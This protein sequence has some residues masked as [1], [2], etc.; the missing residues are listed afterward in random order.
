MSPAVVAA[1]ARPRRNSVGRLAAVPAIAYR[2]GAAA[3]C[4]GTC[5]SCFK[6]KRHAER[7][8]PFVGGQRPKEELVMAGELA[9]REYSGGVTASVVVTCLMAA[10]CG[11]IFGFDFGVSGEDPS[12]CSLQLCIHTA[13]IASSS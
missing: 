5:I 2:P 3:L 11:L 13:P 1:A 9:A 10:S 4:L 6:R 12:L 7:R 8:N